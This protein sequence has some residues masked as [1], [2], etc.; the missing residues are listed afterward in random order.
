VLVY[1]LDSGALIAAERGERWVMK[2]FAL[3]HRGQALLLVPVVCVLEWWRGR[4]DVREEILRAAEVEPLTLAIAKAAGQAQ[5]KVKGSTPIDSAV[6]A[7]A[8]LRGGVV[9][10]RDVG[11][12]EKLREHFRGVRVL[13]DG[14]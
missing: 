5:A 6:M 7:T 8:A 4:T 2:F 14:R 13:G 11:D 3:R 9:V 10:T 12:F 1:V